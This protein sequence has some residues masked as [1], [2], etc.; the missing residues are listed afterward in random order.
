MSASF[1][2]SSVEE[3]TLPAAVK[4]RMYKHNFEATVDPTVDDDQTEKYGPGSLWRNQD[5]ASWWICIDNTIGGAAWVTLAII[6]VFA[7]GF[8]QLSYGSEA[9]MEPDTPYGTGTI[10]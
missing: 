10:T 7:I 2:G 1:M 9:I 8:A 4:R 3:T 5:S 6:S